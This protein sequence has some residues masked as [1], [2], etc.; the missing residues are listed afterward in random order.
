MMMSYTFVTASTSFIRERRALLF[1]FIFTCT[2]PS[3]CIGVLSCDLNE[4]GSG[5]VFTFVRRRYPAL[6][7][8]PPCDSDWSDVFLPVLLTL[9]PISTACLFSQR[10]YATGNYLQSSGTMLDGVVVDVV[11][12]VAGLGR[13]TDPCPALWLRF[14][15]PASPNATRTTRNERIIRLIRSCVGVCGCK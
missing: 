8:R 4:S 7:E 6:G 2:H 3:V 5:D 10:S 15:A 13:G 12:V 1:I 11:V 9:S 14:A